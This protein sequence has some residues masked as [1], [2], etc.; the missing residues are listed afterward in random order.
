MF[1]C[2][3]NYYTQTKAVPKG[4][5]QNLLNIDFTLQDLFHLSL[6]RALFHFFSSN[7]VDRFRGEDQVSLNA[8]NNR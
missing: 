5:R 8:L 2:L 6:L 7:Q 3:A 1:L 4:N